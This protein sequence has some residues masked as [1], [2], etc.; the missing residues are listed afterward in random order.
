MNIYL[1]ESDQFVKHKLKTKYYIRY[2][3]DFVILS[4]ER[5]EL[6]RLLPYIEAFLRE[7][8]KLSLLGPLSHGNAF[9]LQKKVE[10]S[11]SS[12]YESSNA[13]SG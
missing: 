10:A 1:N 12:T 3:D 9:T 4:R 5:A 13:K 8:L 6:E 7:R 11:Y 2:A